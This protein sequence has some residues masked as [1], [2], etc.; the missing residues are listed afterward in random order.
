MKRLELLSN[1]IGQPNQEFTYSVPTGPKKKGETQIYRK[2]SHSKGIATIPSSFPSLASF[3]DSSV[4]NYPNNLYLE[5]LTFKKVDDLAKRVGSWIK[6]R[7][8]K[9]FFLYCLNSVN[10]T[11][12]DIASWNYGL[13]N[14]PL[15]DTLGPE[16]FNHILKITEGTLLFTTKNLTANLLKFLSKNKYNLKE[17]CVFD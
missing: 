5:D 11:I 12:T 3:W 14:V 17:V 6:S 1:Q 13:I 7:G 15:Y 9:L 2:P 10:W 4:K 8:H 16:A